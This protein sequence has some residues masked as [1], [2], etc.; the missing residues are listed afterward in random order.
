MHRG[1]FESTKETKEDIEFE[2]EIMG[3]QITKLKFNIRHW[4]HRIYYTITFCSI[5]NQAVVPV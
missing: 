4:D 5:Y 1:S 3:I 2:F